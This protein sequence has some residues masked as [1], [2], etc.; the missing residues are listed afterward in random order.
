MLERAKPLMTRNLLLSVAAVVVG[1]I[2]V[3][4]AEFAPLH[5]VRVIGAGLIAGG[6]VAI[7]IFTGLAD[8][9]SL[10]V[11]ATLR[12]WRVGL[13]VAA[14]ALMVLPVA[15]VLVATLF[16]MG[17][18]TAEARSGSTNALGVVIS[19][20]LLAATAVVAVASIR[21]IIRA[22]TEPPRTSA[23]TGEAEK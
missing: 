16:G 8:P 12:S 20:A 23:D 11:P 7:G 2:I 4:I 10:R 9:R 21:A 17:A 22:G 13:G 19:L 3:A 18:D 1:I 15:V 14:A 6:G 5:E